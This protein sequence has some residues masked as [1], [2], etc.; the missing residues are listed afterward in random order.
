MEKPLIPILCTGNSYRSQMAENI[1]R[2]VA[3]D[4][5]EV[6]SASIRL[7]KNESSEE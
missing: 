6:E 5:V 3:G 2:G 7:P 1:L 4:I